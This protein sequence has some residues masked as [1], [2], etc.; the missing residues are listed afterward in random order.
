MKQGSAGRS[1]MCRDRIQFFDVAAG[2]TACRFRLTAERVSVSSNHEKLTLSATHQ[3]GRQGRLPPRRG[4]RRAGLVVYAAM[5]PTVVPPSLQQRLIERTRPPGAV[6]MYQRWE[7]L[8][9]L[10]WRYEIATVQASLPP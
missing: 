3:N 4:H 7:H 1:A 5:I 10:H 6:V 2:V 9:F 8:L